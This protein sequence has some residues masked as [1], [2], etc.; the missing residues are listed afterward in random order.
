MKKTIRIACLAG[1]LA[2]APFSLTADDHLPKN[3]GE[4]T[5]QSIADGFDQGAHSS[6]PS[7]D[8]KGKEDRVGLANVVER[9]NL[10]ATFELLL[11]LM[12]GGD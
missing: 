2:L 4:L 12:F 3:W 6:D 7:G 1:V 10:Q 5:S 9:G 11:S 8:G